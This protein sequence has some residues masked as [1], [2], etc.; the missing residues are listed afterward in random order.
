MTEL[1]VSATWFTETS[2]CAKRRGWLRGAAVGDGCGEGGGDG[3]GE[4]GGADGAGRLRAGTAGRR[5]RR[6]AGTAGGWG[7]GLG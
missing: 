1:D 6:A 2:K 5:G 4:D 7:V 3:C